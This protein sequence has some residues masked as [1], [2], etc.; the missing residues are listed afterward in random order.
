MKKLFNEIQE[1]KTNASYYSSRKSLAKKIKSEN[2]FNTVVLIKGSRGM[3]MEEF[4]TLTKE[5]MS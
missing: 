3:Q 4:I 2:F 1:V 5:N